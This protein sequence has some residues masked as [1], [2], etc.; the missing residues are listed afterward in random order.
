VVGGQEDMILDVAV[1]LASLRSADSP[2]DDD[3]ISSR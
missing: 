3:G 1:E 2:P